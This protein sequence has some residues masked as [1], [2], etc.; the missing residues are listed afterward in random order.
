MCNQQILCGHF[1]TLFSVSFILIVKIS[2]CSFRFFCF[3]I[4]D[5]HF[6]PLALIRKHSMQVL[7]K[8]IYKI[9]EIWVTESEMSLLQILRSK[10]GLF[11][12]TQRVF[13]PL[14]QSLYVNQR[15]ALV[16]SL[17]YLF[18]YLYLYLYL[19][20]HLYIFIY[21]HLYVDKTQPD[22][23]CCICLYLYCTCFFVYICNL[24]TYVC[25]FAFVYICMCN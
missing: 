24:Y 12:V 20:L 21:S 23:N 10:F 25:L 4:H 19:H 9:L 8:A 7:R 18:P 2:L 3:L 6:R 16:V 11:L 15:V 1:P 5:F 14:H 17:F 13:S 22:L